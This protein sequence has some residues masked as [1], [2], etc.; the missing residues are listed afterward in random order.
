M[1][2][3]EKKKFDIQELRDTKVPLYLAITH[4]TVTTFQPR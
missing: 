1:I 3:T 2:G 4:F